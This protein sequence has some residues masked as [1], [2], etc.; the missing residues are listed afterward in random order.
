[1]PPLLLEKTLETSIHVNRAVKLLALHPLLFG[2]FRLAFPSIDGGDDGWL[3]FGDAE[4]GRGEPDFVASGGNP[5]GHVSADDDVQGGTWYHQAPF[6]YHGDFS[7]AYGMTFTF[8]L[9]QSTLA[10][11]FDS[12]DVILTG[13]GV[14]IAVDAGSN[15]GTAWTSYTVVLDESAGWALDVWDGTPATQADIQTVLSDLT[16][17][18]IRGEFVVGADTGGLDNVVLNSTCETP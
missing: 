16:D 11:Q 8:D 17:L 15:P 4:G 2:H 12:N 9:K 7:G 5:G 14:T 13:G 10:S 6:K 18:R 3:I 1:M